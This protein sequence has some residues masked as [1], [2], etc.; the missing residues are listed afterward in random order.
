MDPHLSAM[1]PAQASQTAQP[2]DHK[3]S[4][5]W[6]KVGRATMLGINSSELV[7]VQC[8]LPGARRKM[9]TRRND[10]AISHTRM[11]SEF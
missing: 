2:T 11:H 3:G 5:P 1:G 9:S 6:A 7:R 8:V 4:P 10:L